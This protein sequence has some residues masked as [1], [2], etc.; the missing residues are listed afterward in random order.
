MEL[1]P[2]D[3]LILFGDV[4]QQQT[5]IA[6][7]GCLADDCIVSS[8]AKSQGWCFGIRWPFAEEKKENEKEREPRKRFSS[9]AVVH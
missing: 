5:D 4:V 3:W 7:R 6:A 9:G 1:V 2:K 8:M